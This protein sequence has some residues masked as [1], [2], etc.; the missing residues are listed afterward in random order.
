M[1]C[2]AL[3]SILSF[4]RNEYSTVK[5]RWIFCDKFRTFLAHLR[6]RLIRELILYPCS[7]VR[8]RPSFTMFKHLL[9]LNRLANYSLILCGA[10]MGRGNESL[11]VASGSQIL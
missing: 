10:S 1:R 9:L 5:L 11:F 8:R 3:P 2:E 6:R 7:G 4:F